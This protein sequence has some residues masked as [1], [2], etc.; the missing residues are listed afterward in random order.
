MAILNL[1]TRD[2][3][4]HDDVGFAG[5]RRVVVSDDV[6]VNSDSYVCGAENGHVGVQNILLVSAVRGVDPE[7]V[8]V[9]VA[10]AV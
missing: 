10:R 7:N 2:T 1:V 3:G 4:A 9:P 8:A 6:T 5:G